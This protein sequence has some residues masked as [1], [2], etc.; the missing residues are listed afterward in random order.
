MKIVIPGGSGQVGRMLARSFHSQGHDITVLSR[1]PASAPWR[2]VQWDGIT[3]G[4]WI[5]AL[6]KTDVCINLTGRS[7]NCR[8]TKHNRRAIYDSRIESTR[9]LNEVIESLK[10]P[11]RLWLNASTATIYR[12]SLDREMGES[13]GELGGG[14]PGVP[15]TWNFSIDVAKGWEEAFFSKATPQTRKIAMRS[16]ITFSP[17]RNGAFDVLSTLV[18]CGL[19]GTQGSGEQYVSWI[20]ET[21]FIRAIEFLIAKQEFSGVVNIASPNP[22]QNVEFMRGLREAWGARIGLPASSWMI[23]MGAFVMRT[24]SELV[25]KSRRVVPEKLLQAGFKF[26]YPLWPAAARELVGRAKTI[27]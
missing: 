5:S 20:H 14:E 24:E 21:D 15:D 22:L 13:N 8:Y 6:E 1:Q 9:L 16:S 26:M 27:I 4:C 18:R 10:H 11:P 23:E 17:D 19:G 7:V 12:H 3:P 2:V 25:M